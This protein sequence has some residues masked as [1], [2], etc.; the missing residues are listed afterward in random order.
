MFFAV[1][2]A[3]YAVIAMGCDPRKLSVKVPCDVGY[4]RDYYYDNDYCLHILYNV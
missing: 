4:G 3:E 2:V 1:N